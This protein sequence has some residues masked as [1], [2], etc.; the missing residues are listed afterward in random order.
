MLLDGE[1]RTV[2]VVG[3]VVGPEVGAVPEDRAVLHQPVVEEDLLAP[4]DVLAGEQGLAR[5]IDDPV[6]NRRVGCVGPVGEEA[7]DE[8]PDQEDDDGRLD[9]GLRDQELTA[10]RSLFR[11][12]GFDLNT[13]PGRNP[14]E[15]RRWERC[16]GALAV[17][18]PNPS[19]TRA[20]PQQ[21]RSGTVGINSGINLSA[22]GRN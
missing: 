22:S 21:A 16:P 20:R 3:R 1:R 2:E 17:R 9:P 11:H 8:E 12:R 7:E 6:G 18:S 4:A 10:S 5:G 13:K 14:D 19:A 15:R